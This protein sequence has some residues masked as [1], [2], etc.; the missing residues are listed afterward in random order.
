MGEARDWVRAAGMPPG[1]QQAVSLGQA[2]CGIVQGAI[3]RDEYKAARGQVE[4]ADVPAQRLLRGH[5][6]EAAAAAALYTTKAA[7][8]AQCPAQPQTLP[9]HTLGAKAQPNDAWALEREQRLSS[10]VADTDAFASTTSP[11]KAQSEAHS[12]HEMEVFSMSEGAAERDW[13]ACGDHDGDDDATEAE[14][15]ESA[16]MKALDDAARDD[17]PC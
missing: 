2:G 12:M 13:P 11:A 8:A 5:Y 9:G 4:P 16:L 1:D 3:V 7:A 10:S 14:L 17:W 15:D 6:E